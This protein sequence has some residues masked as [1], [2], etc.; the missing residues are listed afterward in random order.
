[1]GGQLN[2]STLGDDRPKRHIPIH[3]HIIFAPIGELPF[4]MGRGHRQLFQN[5]V[6]TRN[7]RIPNDHIIL[8]G[9]S[10]SDLCFL[11]KNPPF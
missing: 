7:P 8:G 2:H 3:R 9:A 1:M 5:E 10:H 11:L 6:M 4:V